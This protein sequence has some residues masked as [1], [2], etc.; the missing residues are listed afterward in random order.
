MKS[1]QFFPSSQ[2]AASGATAPL[3]SS[4]SEGLCPSSQPHAKAHGSATSENPPV[5]VSLE[6]AAWRVS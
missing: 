3:K 6:F 1:Q 4:A 2:L 5:M